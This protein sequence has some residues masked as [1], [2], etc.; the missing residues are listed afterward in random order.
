MT[1]GHG[2]EHGEHE[3]HEN[4]HGA[5]DHAAHGAHAAPPP[6]KAGTNHGHA[7][8]GG[9]S[10]GGHDKHAG[11]SPGMF[12]DRFLL[13]LLLTIPTLIWGHMLQSAFGYAAP[14]FPG[15]HWIPAAF[16][17]AVFVTGGWPFL[18]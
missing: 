14:V 15:S 7:A 4:A 13:S 5:H 3:H 17:T 18:Q 11:H 2:T 6:S 10:H 12:R 1:H 16:G 9:P 8:H